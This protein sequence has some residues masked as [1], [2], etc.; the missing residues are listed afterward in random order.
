MFSNDLVIL[1]M[2]TL[3]YCTQLILYVIFFSVFEGELS[4]VIPVVHASVAGCRI[5]GRLTAG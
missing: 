1:I 4:D 2:Y 5:I 3:L